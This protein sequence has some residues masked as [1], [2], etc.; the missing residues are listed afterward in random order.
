MRTKLLLIAFLLLSWQ[1]YSIIS[2]L[3]ERLEARSTQ[4]ELMIQELEK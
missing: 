1:S 2:T 3:Y 4:L